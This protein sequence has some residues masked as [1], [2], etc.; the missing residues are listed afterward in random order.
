MATNCIDTI[1]VEAGGLTCQD[2]FDIFGITLA[3]FY[4]WNPTVGPNCAGLWTG[5]ASGFYRH[6]VILPSRLTRVLGY[7]YCIETDGNDPGTTPTPSTSSTV[8]GPQ[9]PGPTQSGQ[10][11]NCNRWHLTQGMHDQLS[12]ILLA[13]G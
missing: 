2:I 12:L 11:A 4:A 9:P 7:R 6:P 5:N 1:D 10:P 8:V 3:Q 13:T